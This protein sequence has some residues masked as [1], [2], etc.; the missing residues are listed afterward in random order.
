MSANNLEPGG[1]EVWDESTVWMGGQGDRDDSD[2]GQA[3]IVLPMQLVRLDSAGF[4]HIGHQRD[5][6]EDNFNIHTQISAASGLGWQSFSAKGLYILCDGM[7]GHSG[8]EVASALVVAE[9]KR[10]LDEHWQM[11]MPDEATIRAAIDHANQVVYA[12]N[13][14]DDRLGSGRMGTTLVVLLLQGTSAALAHVGDSRIYTYSRREGLQQRTVDHEVGQLE[15]MRGVEPEI[16]YGR[17][18]SYQLTQALGPKGNDYINP[19]VQFLEIQEDTLF[20]LCSDGLSDYNLVEEHGEEKLAPLL[21]SQAS[22][23]QGVNDLVHLANEL[24][25]H[26]NI[27]A[28]AVRAKVRP[29]VRAL[30]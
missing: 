24:N 27:T 17:P 29:D 9:L 16:A 12:A 2:D 7:G 21:S 6:N 30:Q 5:H 11:Q 22:L 18:E 14:S 19:D 25:G 26:D 1:D 8:G 10:Y 20:L 23:E 15:L 4:S 13:E 28:I 3:T